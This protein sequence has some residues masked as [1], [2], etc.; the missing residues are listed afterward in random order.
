MC[1]YDLAFSPDGN[2][3]PDGW[4]VYEAELM[5]PHEIIL[6]FCKTATLCNENVTVMFTLVF[7]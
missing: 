7:F 6:V 2:K 5:V 3:Q 4:V 1:V